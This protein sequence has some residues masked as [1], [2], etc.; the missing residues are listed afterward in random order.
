MRE[1]SHISNSVNIFSLQ[2]AYS[3]H[4]NQSGNTAVIDTWLFGITIV[5]GAVVFATL[6]LL[7][8]R[9]RTVA[10]SLRHHHEVAG[11]LLSIVGTLYS[12]LLGLIVVDTQGKYAEAKTMTQKEADSCLDLFHLAY[13]MP[14][15]PRRQLHN[16]VIE[17]LKVMNTD[18]WNSIA[19]GAFDES[20]AEPFRSIWWTLV[21]YEPVTN[22]QT[23]AYSKMLDVMQNLTDGRRYRLQR[24]RTGLPNVLWGVL[25]AGGTLTVLFTYL[26]EVEDARA[27]VT[28]TALVA[29]ALSLNLLL[30]ALFNNP[31]KGHL[32]ISNYPFQYDQV[33][34]VHLLQTHP[35]TK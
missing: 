18:E 25:I 3:G 10:G 29:L 8:V 28:M 34:I 14:M 2:S 12:V 27:H 16:E 19:H 21:D 15:Q 26:F 4:C 17:Y 13:T 24:S 31:Y 1:F 20:A 32:K 23:E 6:G 30:I 5:G 7:L 11:Y 22:K 9:K 33:V 35:D